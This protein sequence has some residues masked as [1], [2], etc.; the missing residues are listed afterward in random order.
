MTASDTRFVC[1]QRIPHRILNQSIVKDIDL[2]A[3]NIME[4]MLVIVSFT[5]FVT[6]P[7]GCFLRRITACALWYRLECGGRWSGALAVK[8][9]VIVLAIHLLRLH[10]IEKVHLNLPG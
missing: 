8:G 9:D 10:I 1:N 6:A 5:Q 7:D 4:M 2:L 3:M